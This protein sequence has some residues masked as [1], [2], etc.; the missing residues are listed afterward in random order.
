MPTPPRGS[1]SAIA[2]AVSPGRVPGSR[3]LVTSAQASK[4]LRSSSI[5]AWAP[6]RATLPSSRRSGGSVA[7]TAMTMARAARSGSPGCWPHTHLSPAFGDIGTA[8]EALNRF[9]DTPFG[10]VRIN[11]PNSIAPFVLGR[12]IGPLL[13]GNPHLELEIAATDRL[14]DIVAEGFDA[15]I[16]LGESL[17]D[18]MVAVRIGPRLRF[19]VV[20]SPGYFAQ[21]GAPRTPRELGEHRCVQNMYPTGARYPWA[22]TGVARPSPSIRPARSRSTTTS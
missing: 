1:H 17:R 21:R 18:G 19:A 5:L 20:G 14:V 10:K 22:F 4:S 8:L 15:G 11:V 16:R 6:A 13:Q 2:V 3:R 7:L 9:R 12:V